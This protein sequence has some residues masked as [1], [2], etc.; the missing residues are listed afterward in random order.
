MHTPPRVS[1]IIIFLNEERFL[2]EAIESVLA[3][4]F[5]G[6]EL[7]LVDDG[8]TDGSSAIA[9]RY[10]GRDPRIRVVTHADRENRGMSASRNR[11]VSVSVGEFIGFLDGDDAWLPNKLADQL[12][13]MDRHPEVAMLYGRTQWWFSW[14]GDAQVRDYL[15]EPGVELGKPIQPPQLLPSLIR[16]DGSP[17]YTCSIIIRRSKYL[18]L[19][20]FEES[21][22]GLHEDQAFF[23]KAF[24][25]LTVLVSEHCSDRYRQHPDSACAVGLRTGELHAVDL[26]P[27][28]GRLP[29]MAQPIP[30]MEQAVRSRGARGAAQPRT[31]RVSPPDRSPETSSR[32]HSHRRLRRNLRERTWRFPTP[33]TLTGGRLLHLLGW[34]IGKERPR[35]PRGRPKW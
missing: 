16:A 27:S 24:A 25:E 4:T 10:G 5:E 23:A 14:N 17:P 31:G 32:C 21:F 34:A 6:W 15:Y 26:S 20:G 13:L 28:P 19:G 33:E 3:Q 7:I 1:V 9:A 35:R 29:R 8:S 30:R 12:D 11:G 18:R 2:T 22:I